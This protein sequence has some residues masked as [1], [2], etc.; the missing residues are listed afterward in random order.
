MA[1]ATSDVLGILQPTLRSPFD[2]TGS[3]IGFA[4]VNGEDSIPDIAALMSARP[5]VQKIFGSEHA[6]GAT[7][8]IQSGHRTS[9]RGEPSAELGGDMPRMAARV[10][11]TSTVLTGRWTRR[12]A[13]PGP[14]KT[15]G[16]W[17]S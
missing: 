9:E 5:V 15:T 8:T 7:G 17:V 2:L 10:G 13:T 3:V 16:T 6:V 14:T 4:A 1:A 12:A 11:A